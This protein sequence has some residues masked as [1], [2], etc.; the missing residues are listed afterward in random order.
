M[1]EPVE[2]TELRV[3]EEDIPVYIMTF[4]DVK[5]VKELKPMLM[6]GRI[7]AALVSAK[8]I[9]SPF[10]LLVATNIA[11][12]NQLDG[13]MKTKNINSE[14][15]FSLSP[16]K[17]ISEAFRSFGAGP[18]DTAVAAVAVSDRSRLEPL[19]QALQG[20]AVPPEQLAQLAD[21]QAV[22]KQYAVTEQELTV[23]TLEQAVVSRIASRCAT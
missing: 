23:G 17:Q 15:I 7:N 14:I 16:G 3:G 8:K 13:T 21:E 5:N 12:H 19:C 10:Q 9:V 1:P 18:G 4:K 11:L 22:I 6:D 2:T 20:T